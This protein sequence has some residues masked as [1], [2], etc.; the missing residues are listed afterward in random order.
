VIEAAIASVER[1]LEILKVAPERIEKLIEALAVFKVTR[2]MPGTRVS[3]KLET[4]SAT[5]LLQLMKI[6]NS[7][8]DELS[9]ASDWFEVGPAPTAD[10]P[11]KRKSDA[12]KADPAAQS[13][14]ER[15]PDD[16]PPF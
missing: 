9:K 16:D 7:L 12:A 3:R 1:T 10:E 13:K 11:S 6:H 14:R 8:R 5:V 15:V 2:P 4:I